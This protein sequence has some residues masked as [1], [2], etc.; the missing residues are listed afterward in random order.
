MTR[1][2]RFVVSMLACLVFCVPPTHAAMDFDGVDDFAQGD[3]ISTFYSATDL[4]VMA[5]FTGAGTSPVGASFCHDTESQAPVGNSGGVRPR[6]SP[7]T[8]VHCRVC[9]AS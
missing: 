6:A 8:L 1:L 2:P 3:V 4:T 5:W 9:H 7:A